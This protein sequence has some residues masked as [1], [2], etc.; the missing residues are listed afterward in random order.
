M[1]D[2][3]VREYERVIDNGYRSLAVFGLPLEEAVYGVMAAFDSHIVS[4]WM[5][6]EQAENG[7]LSLRQAQLFKFLGEGFI[8]ATRWLLGRRESVDV[9]PSP[10]KDLVEIGNELIDYGSKYFRASILYSG[11]TQGKMEAVVFPEARRVRFA[12]KATSVAENAT[13]GFA[14]EASLELS[15]KTPERRQLSQIL[16]GRAAE[17]FRQTPHRLEAG[18][19]VL[20]DVTALSDD[21]VRRWLDF[22]TDRQ[23]FFPADTDVGGF[24]IGEFDAF[25][26]ALYTWSVCVTSIYSDSCGRRGI[27]QEQS[28]PTQVVRRGE[29]IRS[30]ATLSG[31][32]RVTVESILGRLKADHR[33]NKLDMYLQP[34]LCGG[35]WV[36]W[37]VRG[38]QM[39]VSQRNLLKLMART[40]AHKPMADAIIGGRERSL[41]AEIATWLKS[42]GWTVIT[43]RELPGLEDG[44]VDLIGWNW[45]YPSEVLI[46]EAKAL[47]QADD[48]NEVRSATREM[49]HAQ[50]QLGR[51]IRILSGLPQA[52]RESHFHFVEWGKVT[53][54]YGVVIT[55]EGEPGLEY[56]H[57]TFPACS[58]VGLRQ[59]LS[60]KEWRSPSR[61]W[62]AMVVRKWQAEIRAGRVE[63][64]PFEL[65]GVTFEEPIL[66]Y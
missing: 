28:M 39:S 54:W 53:Q 66:V 37:S 55:P 42:K 62:N 2:A 10:R 61:L 36:A 6:R 26:R 7:S 60:A 50:E 27:P 3:T 40:P 21:R 35:E 24:T 47:L 38:V 43:N 16:Q 8:L 48:P 25:W 15:R 41:L 34:L 23:R 9:R 31:L 1:S 51:I 14:E 56:N 12:H 57:A 17:V 19:I 45:S 49:Q 30:M 64:E 4:E 44:E 29:F 13:W 52:V 11:Y 63:Y 33:T 32:P 58:F 59:R 22:T 65:A 46:I 20:E 18:R 5:V